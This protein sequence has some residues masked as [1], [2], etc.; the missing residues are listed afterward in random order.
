[1]NVRHCQAARNI[2]AVFVAQVFV[3]DVAF[4][5]GVDIMFREKC[6]DDEFLGVRMAIGDLVDEHDRAA[7]IALV[8]VDIR[9]RS[10]G[11]DDRFLA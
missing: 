10:P 9:R 8:R 3:A 4:P 2:L 7:R 1:V 5:E 6:P 11:H